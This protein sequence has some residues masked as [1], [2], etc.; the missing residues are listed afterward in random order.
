MYFVDCA[1]EAGFSVGR[2]QHIRRSVDDENLFGLHGAVAVDDDGIGKNKRGAAEKENLTKQ[3]KQ[4]A[5]P[6][7]G[8]T[9]FLVL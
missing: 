4:V 9:F 8:N 6:A 1:L 2:R 5:K 7:D 3:N